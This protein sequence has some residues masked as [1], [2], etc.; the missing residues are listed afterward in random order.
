MNKK[1]NIAID[2]PAG[3]GKSTIARAV[4]AR[5]GL[6]YV[7]TG[8]IYRSVGLYV[9]RKGVGSKDRDRIIAMLPEIEIRIVHDETGKQLMMLNGE[10]V[11]EA[12]RMPEISIY[13]SDVSAI[14]EVRSFL[15]DLQRD[16]ARKHGTVMDGR[17][18]GTV[19]LPDAALKIFL[20]ASAEIRAKRRYR[21]LCEKGV[22]TTYEAVLEDM[23]YRDAN[24]SGRSVAPLKAAEDAVMLDTSELT[25]EE[26][27]QA[28][29]T[30]A[31]ERMGE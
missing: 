21:E 22:D 20:T 9:C 23:K 29:F 8:A 26:S 28:V 30:L 1:F 19:V 16:F 10:D 6:I 11:S 27:I 25:L 7:D 4:S 13:A 14:P 17:D 3:A 18:I 31:E 2:G 5:L 12:I 24:D 15:L